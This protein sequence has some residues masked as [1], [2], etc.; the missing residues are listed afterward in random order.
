MNSRLA[1]SGE[2]TQA[3]GLAGGVGAPAGGVAGGADEVRGSRLPLQVELPP[4]R[5]ASA[6]WVLEQQRGKK[7]KQTEGPPDQSTAEEKQEGPRGWWGAGSCGAP[8]GRVEAPGGQRRE[9]P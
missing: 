5:G 7:R 3:A 1:S 6:R 4:Q 2:R 9:K 8:Q